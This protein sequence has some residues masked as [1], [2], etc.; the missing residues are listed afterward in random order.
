MSSAVPAHP[1]AMLCIVHCIDLPQPVDG[2]E[3]F[4]SAWFF[5]DNEG[6]RF[7]VE[8]GPAATIPYLA[9]EL[10]KLTNSLDYILLTHI[11]L[12]HSG[13]L[14]HL[15]KYYPNAKV[16][17]SPKGRK[18]LT[19]P[20]KLWSAS[21]STLGE[22]AKLY[23]E[24]LPVPSDVFLNEGEGI[25]GVE[26]IETPGHAPHHITF[27]IPFKS[28]HLLFVGEALGITIPDTEGLYLR[29]TTPPKFDAQAAL[30]SLDL[31]S[32]ASSENDILCFAHFGY[33]DNAL[34]IIAKS[35]EQ[36]LLWMNKSIEWR[37]KGIEKEQMI[38]LLL[39]SDPMLADFKKLSKQLQSRELRFIGNSLDG[40]I[41]ASPLLK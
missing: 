36:L 22:I 12:D 21:I 31:L 17:V 6:R 38:E 9:T 2:F 14:G 5:E 41:D 24:P 25:E 4:I 11:H 33:K 34:Q 1:W 19:A 18:H 3:E 26:V 35:K 8:T 39:T 16:L 15:L 28:K 20:G 27:R 30:S 40:I 23:G 32:K 10:S 13:G 37:E 29:P 7:L